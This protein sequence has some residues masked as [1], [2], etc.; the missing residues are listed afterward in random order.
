MIFHTRGE[1]DVSSYGA[2]TI[3]T[4]LSFR[5][6]V[7]FRLP[8]FSH[9]TNIIITRCQCLD[10]CEKSRLCR[11]IEAI[12]LSVSITD[13]DVNIG[14]WHCRDKESPSRR[15]PSVGSFLFGCWI[16]C[17]GDDFVCLWKCRILVLFFLACFCLTELSKRWIQNECLLGWEIRMTHFLFIVFH[18]WHTKDT[19]YSCF[20]SRPYDSLCAV[21]FL[22]IFIISVLER[23]FCENFWWLIC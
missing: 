14:R 20:W 8:P 4:I 10:G 21:V 16:M 19:K 22:F 15:N 5:C 7:T 11:R 3:R 23:R 6:L 18:K 13:S 9:R 1:D 17:T 2:L 12:L